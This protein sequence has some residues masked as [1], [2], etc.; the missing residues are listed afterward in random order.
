MKHLIMSIALLTGT[1]P[2]T[3]ADLSKDAWDKTFPKSDKV[4]HR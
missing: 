2:V 3:A 1:L 4:E